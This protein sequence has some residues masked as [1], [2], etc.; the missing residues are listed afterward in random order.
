MTDC[1]WIHFHD[2]DDELKSTFSSSARIWMKQEQYDVVLFSYDEIDEATGQHIATRSFDAPALEADALRYAILNQINPFCGL[3]KREPFL[4]AGGYDVDPDVL[5]NE[6]VA[7][8]IRLAAAGLRFSAD[9]RTEVINHRRSDSMSSGN[10]SKC[11][12]AQ[13]AVLRKTARTAPPTYWPAIGTRLWA[14]AGVAASID[15]WRTAD[16][17][18]VLA[19]ELGQSPEP[20]LFKLLCSVSPSFA[21][22]IRE[23]LIRLL[24]PGLRSNSGLAA[25]RRPLLGKGRVV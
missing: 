18:V 20:G 22:R 2:A 24:K 4:A 7:M 3:Y 15:D 1:D 6:D 25:T 16:S 17:C 11:I 10:V 19:G 5:Y 14:V 21:L 8:H 23:C 13:F 9:P 12:A